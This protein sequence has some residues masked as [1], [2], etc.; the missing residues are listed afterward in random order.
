MLEDLYIFVDREYPPDWQDD[1]ENTLWLELL[2]PFA[3]VKNLYLCEQIVPHIAPALHELVGARITEVLPILETIFLEQFESTHKGIEN[4]VAARRR[5]S[6]SYPVAVSH[7]N[8]DQD[9]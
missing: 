4:F 5:S 2:H 9:L 8:R 1:V 6:S 3:A 7:W